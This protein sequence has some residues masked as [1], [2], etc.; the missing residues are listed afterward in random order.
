MGGKALR[1]PT[2]SSHRRRRGAGAKRKASL[3]GSPVELE[4][5]GQ[6]PLSEMASGDRAKWLTEVAI[7]LAQRQD[8]AFQV[9]RLTGNRGL[10]SLVSGSGALLRQPVEHGSGSGGSTQVPGLPEDTV[11]S[12]EAN[13]QADPQAAIDAISEAMVA[14]GELDL[15]HLTDRGIS[16]VSDSSRMPPGHYGYT[17]LSPGSGLPRPCR[18]LIGP[19]ATRSVGLL[20]SVMLHEARHVEQFRAGRMTEEA[21]TEFESYLLEIENMER[22]GQ[23]RDAAYIQTLNSVTRDW[24]E[25]LAPEEQ[26]TYQ[27]RYREARFTLENANRRR[28]L[29]AAGQGQRVARKMDPE[30]QDGPESRPLRSAPA[31]MVMTAPDDG[32]S[33]AAGEAGRADAATLIQS[34]FPHLMRALA[35]EQIAKVQR[36]LDARRHN[37]KVANRV[38][39][40]KRR[41]IERYG[42]ISIF[43]DDI[44][45]L[46]RI[47]RGYRRIPQEGMTLRVDTARLLSPDILA[48][49]P[50]NV[51]AE[52]KFRL[53]LWDELSLGATRLD[54]QSGEAPK[55]I[56]KVVWEGEK[57]AIALPNE[58][59]RVTWDHLMQIPRFS[60]A[61]FKFVTRGPAVEQMFR[62]ISAARDD[63]YHEQWYLMRLQELAHENWWA[64]YWSS[65]IA[66]AKLPGIDIFWPAGKKLDSAFEHMLEGRLELAGMLVVSA[67]E[68]IQQARN[69]VN[70][71][72][73]QIMGGAARAVRGLT[74]AKIAGGVAATIATG[75]LALKAGAGLVGLSLASAEGAG[76]YTFISEE[77]QQASAIHHGLREE[78]DFAT[79]AKMAGTDAVVT[80]AGTLT[81]GAL[82]GKFHRALSGVMSRAGMGPFWQ[83]VVIDGL[84]AVGAAP[85]ATGTRVVMNSIVGGGKVP[86]SLDEM[87]D[88]IAEETIKGGASQIFLGAMMRRFAP[89]APGG[90]GGGGADGRRTLPGLGP[91]RP[92]GAVEPGKTLPGMGPGKAPADVG[93]ARTLRPEEAGRTLTPEE[94]GRT[95]TPEEA[96]RT[97]TPEEAAQTLP[98]VDP[99]ARTLRPEE[100]AK[101]LPMGAGPTGTLPG[102]GFRPKGVAGR[103][104]PGRKMAFHP[105]EL[106]PGPT[107][108]PVNAR[109]YQELLKHGGVT[110]LFSP[111]DKV[112]WKGWRYH[113]S[114]T[115]DTYLEVWRMAGGEGNPPPLGFID[116]AGRV[117]RTIHPNAE[118]HG[119]SR[120]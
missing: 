39:L 87:I 58:G 72:Q 19:D 29:E 79:I 86:E 111:A 13:L 84:A 100:A 116:R 120:P 11:R 5:G 59:G 76:V 64:H 67:E 17:S 57:G 70:R 101:T 36:V 12:A 35:P 55:P 46:D 62:H 73:A 50:W 8:M 110:H 83:G 91:G 92:P 4:S 103:P 37:Q 108:E 107:L 10:G 118:I 54:I 96:G 47:R 43:S 95:L 82:A 114:Y 105:G 69:S 30:T 75:G 15:G 49:Q 61:Y 119:R 102:L 60:Q 38:E 81:G 51:A 63:M 14:Q 9:G 3:K 6:R 104:I 65:K 28:I 22:T 45:R 24:W 66:G 56:F 40:E 97:L 90:G 93:G 26:E 98:G 94:A 99:Y 21:A 20:Y 2:N 41:Q 25:R 85:V 113:E 16:Y 115:H 27:D 89:T 33:T 112:G 32:P 106:P 44:D 34:Q 42:R 48:P 109:Q 80:F 68:Q 71:A 18:V 74:Y 53:A 78:F 1:K 7:P 31:G 117:V 52:Q 23:W 88:M 77:A